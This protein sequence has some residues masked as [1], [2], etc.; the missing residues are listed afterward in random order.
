M[1]LLSWGN[2]TL[3]SGAHTTSKLSGLPTIVCVPL[4]LTVYSFQVM[5][6]QY[7]LA[8]IETYEEAMKRNPKIGVKRRL[9]QLKDS[10][11][12]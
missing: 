8:A 1:L 6:G 9:G 3:T 12:R 7:N 5:V 10:L 4:S 2:S 11:Q